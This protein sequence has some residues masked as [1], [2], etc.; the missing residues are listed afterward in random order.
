M[1]QQKPKQEVVIAQLI[2]HYKLSA[3][4]MEDPYRV[5]D[6]SSSN[7]NS[8]SNS[9]SQHYHWWCQQT[10]SMSMLVKS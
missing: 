4:D 3:H 9:S 7:S 5:D 6:K 1:P 10:G 8:N 2:T